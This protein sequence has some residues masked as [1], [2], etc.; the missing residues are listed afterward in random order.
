MESSSVSCGLLTKH[1][2]N[3]IFSVSSSG[4]HKHIHVATLRGEEASRGGGRDQGELDLR[5]EMV[6]ISLSLITSPV[7]TPPAGGRITTEAAQE[8]SRNV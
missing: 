3:S 5:V 1:Q 4:F 6:E 2:R 7:F 8:V